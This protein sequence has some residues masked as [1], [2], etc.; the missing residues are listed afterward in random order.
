GAQNALL[1]GGR[2]DGL[3]K[4]LGGPAVPGF[5][6]AS[7]VERLVLSLPAESPGMRRGPDLFIATLGSEAWEQ[8]L[9]L[10]RNLR[11]KDLWIEWEPAAGR[12]PKAQARRA[13]R[14]GARHLLF[15]GDEELQRGIW[16]LKSMEEGSQKEVPASDLD[17]LV[18]ELLR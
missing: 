18:E 14:L 16:T 1:G 11:K 8:A 2:Y 4:S 13:D 17:G 5:G 3:V 6:F 12:S 10:V 15:L 9:I 7:G